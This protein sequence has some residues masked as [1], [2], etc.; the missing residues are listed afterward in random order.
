[1][2]EEKFQITQEELDAAWNAS[3]LNYIEA[4]TDAYLNTLDG[5]LTEYNMD[6]LTAN[7]HTLLAYRYILDEVMEGG[8]IQ[9]IQNGYGPYV[10]DGPFAMMMKKHWEL[11]DFGKFMYEVKKEYHLHKAE[12]EADLNEEQFMALYEQQE[13]MNELGDEFLDKYQEIV[14]PSIADY[15]RKNEEKFVR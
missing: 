4:I 15:V 9:L 10:L 11:V 2:E 1:M 3:P 6:V 14:T 13:K 7:Q 8:F 5:Q 12:L